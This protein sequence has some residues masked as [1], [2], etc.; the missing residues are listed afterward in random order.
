MRDRAIQGGVTPMSVSSLAEDSA[1]RLNPAT[2]PRLSTVAA[3]AAGAAASAAAGG[4]SPEEA[5][6]R[7]QEAAA[8]A[9][10]QV[11]QPKSAGPL[12]QLVKYVP[13]ESITLYVAILGGLGDIK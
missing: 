10:G 4:A 11:A 8:A 6:R 1:L 9:R 3:A 5:T 13:T 7:G 12:A 2:A